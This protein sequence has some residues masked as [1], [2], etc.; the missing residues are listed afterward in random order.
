MERQTLSIS[1]IPA[2]LW[3]KAS[4]SVYIHVH[5]KQ[6]RK[7]YARAFAE[8]A[9][10]KGWQTLSFDLPGHGERTGQPDRCDLLTGV[11]DLNRVADYVFPRWRHVALYACSLGAWFALNACQ[12]RRLE[13][14]LFQSPIVDMRW[15]VAQMMRWSGVTPQRLE[16]ER[17]I[18]T[19]IDTLR[20]DEYQYILAHP[21]EGWP[22]PTCILYAGRDELQPE[23]A[24][25]DFAR[26]HGAALEIAPDSAHPFMK[27]GD[28]SIVEA[29]LRSAMDDADGKG[30]AFVNLRE[31][32]GLSE[33]AAA[34]FHE[35]WGVPEAAYLERIRAYVNGGTEYGWYLCL[36]DGRIVGG[37][38][39][40]DNDFHDRRDLS[41]NVCAVYTE[42][43]CRGRGIA[44]LLLELAVEDMRARGVSPLYLVSDR[45]GFYERY[46]WEFLCT[47]RE[48]DTGKPTRMY[49]H[50]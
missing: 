21:V 45:I 24:V 49:V 35:K 42:A 46:G 41:P 22:F 17:E 31:R 14:C 4:D 25:R 12:D 16:R 15:L 50:R 11:R 2:I 27:P 28:G 29:W 7:E 33:R 40:I 34:W 19:P 26:A 30:L 48:E 44:G 8:I 36:E 5:G 37:L 23:A 43:A 9:G 18:E 1:G 3:G 47:V 32:P 38:G 39:V 6:S 10:E 13:K 20:W